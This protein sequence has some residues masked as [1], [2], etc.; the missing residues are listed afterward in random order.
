M[1][2]DGRGMVEETR[3]EDAAAR[4]SLRDRDIVDSSWDI[5]LIQF[6]PDSLSSGFE[7][8]QDADIRSRVGRHAGKRRSLTEEGR[9]PR[10]ASHAAVASSPTR[11]RIVA[12]IAGVL[13]VMAGVATVLVVL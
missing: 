4:E 8:A 2:V 7:G 10:K 6:A 5:P 3:P 9:V 13:L 12:A 11:G 1:T